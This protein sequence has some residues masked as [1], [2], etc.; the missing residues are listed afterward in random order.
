MSV[1]RRRSLV[2]RGPGSNPGPFAF[3]D[4]VHLFFGKRVRHKQTGR[5]MVMHAMTVLPIALNL[6]I[7]GAR[8]Q[9]SLARRDVSTN[10]IWRTLR[11]RLLGVHSINSSVQEKIVASDASDI[12]GKLSKRP[13]PPPPAAPAHL[14]DIFSQPPPTPRGPNVQLNVR[15]QSATKDKAQALAATAGISLATLI[16]RAIDR[17]FAI[18]GYRTALAKKITNEAPDAKTK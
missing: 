4:G 2:E 7:R 13:A 11:Y 6:Q 17:Q 5:N 8:Y 14:T 18:H 15:V 12:T 3:G 10:V 9:G 1:N 16:E